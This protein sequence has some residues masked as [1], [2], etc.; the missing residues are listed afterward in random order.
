MRRRLAARIAERLAALVASPGSVGRGV[1]VAV[2]AGSTAP[3]GTGLTG[4]S[5]T[6]AGPEPG[7]P[8]GPIR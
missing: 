4:G 3:T 2:A 6:L 1:A 7:R 8:I 5:A